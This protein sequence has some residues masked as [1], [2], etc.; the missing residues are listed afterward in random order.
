MKKFKCTKNSKLS[1]CILDF[2]GDGI[3]Y[4]TLMKLFRKKDIKLNGKR[5]GKDAEVFVGDEI[6][7]YF[8]GNEKELKVLFKC[9]DL[10]A[11]YKPKNITSEEFF[12]KV[13][14][15]YSTAKFV[16]RLDRNTDGIILF[17]LS[18]IGE[19]ELLKG[20]K[21]RTFDKYYL[22]EVYGVPSK[23][24]FTSN[25]YLIKDEKTSYVKVVGDKNLGG[26]KITTE[27]TVLKRGIETSVLEVKLITGKTH[28]IRAH[29]KYLGYPILGDGKYGTN[30]INK[31][32]KLNRQRLTAYKTVLHFEK[33]SPLENLDGKV[34]EIEND[35][36]I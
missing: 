33:N 1:T 16:H 28:Q 21:E 18:D 2:Y 27:F 26:E 4:G 10:I 23:D 7:V 14:E 17:G 31:K 12:D 13:K 5:V 22:A 24:K 25:A 8:D 15:K 35:F 32:F 20:F 36:K 29:L 6:E 3:S 9:D 30:E 19:S 34:I 11:L